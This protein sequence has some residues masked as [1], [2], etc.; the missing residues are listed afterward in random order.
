MANQPA[1]GISCL[2]M[3]SGVDVAELKLPMMVGSIGVPLRLLVGPAF[4]AHAAVMFSAR[5]NSKE[6]EGRGF[7]GVRLLYQGERDRRRSSG[8]RQVTN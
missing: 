8:R 3:E 5:H 7:A 6:A 1:A 2:L 4:R